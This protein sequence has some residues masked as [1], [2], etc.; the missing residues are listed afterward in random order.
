MASPGTFLASE[1]PTNHVKVRNFCLRGAKE[2]NKKSDVPTRVPTYLFLSF[3]GI[4][5]LYGI[6]ALLMQRNGQNRDKEK[7]MGK[8]DRKKVF[9]SLNF[10]GQKFL[11]Y[12]FSQKVF[13][14]VFELPLLR[15]AQK[16]HKNNL[17][18]L[19]NEKRKVPT[20]PI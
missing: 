14:G 8:D 12:E 5:S 15:N 16:R 4:L 6:F 7:F 2:T 20:C 10:F 17:K 11:T 9:V 18:A 1:E 19:I 13:Y 3:F